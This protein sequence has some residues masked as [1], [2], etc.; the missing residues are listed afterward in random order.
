MRFH[1]PALPGQPVRTDNSTCAFT[2]KVR[3]FA[4]MMSARGHKVTVYGMADHD[5]QGEHVICYDEEPPPPFTPEGWSDANA[6]AEAAITQRLQDDDIICLIGGTAQL[7]LRDLPAQTCE[8]GIGY[9][10]SMAGHPRVFES[11]AWMHA[12]YAAEAGSNNDANGNFFDTVIPASFDPTEFT[13]SE[14]K[15]DYLLFV[16]RLIERKGVQVACEVAERLG[17]TLLIAGEGDYEPTYGQVLGK[18]GP[19]DRA[20]LMAHAQA[21]IAPTLYLEPFGFVAIE[22]MLSGTPVL[23]TDWGAFTE[24]V[25]HGT[26]G[27]R[28]HLLQDFCQAFEQAKDLDPTTIRNHAIST[29]SYDAIA[30]QYNTYFDRIKQLKGAGWYA[31]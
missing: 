8:F 30:P 20:H 29:Y 16:G 4:D 12:T 11:Y 7:P 1:L 19:S 14:D 25:K 5:H 28:C 10:A 23:S 21:L 17:C 22:A 31:R 24:T 15:D 6:A 13:Y 3:R 9:G 2:Q 18:V 27:Y 26:T